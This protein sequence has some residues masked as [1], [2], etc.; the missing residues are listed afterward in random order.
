M[1]KLKLVIL[2][3]AV[4]VAA[5]ANDD[6]VV[7]QKTG[8]AFFCSRAGG[9]LGYGIAVAITEGGLSGFEV[10]L[11]SGTLALTPDQKSIGA[12]QPD[13]SLLTIGTIRSLE[14]SGNC[15]IFWMDLAPN[16]KVFSR[17]AMKFTGI[18]KGS[19]TV[20]PVI[21][22]CYDETISAVIKSEDG[23]TV[24]AT[25]SCL[26]KLAPKGQGSFEIQDSNCLVPR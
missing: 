4:S 25:G 21:G 7:Q 6:V 13:G 11:A 14:I 10:P 20:F 2:L 15:K 26:R 1:N 23:Q 8:G 16:S 19:G 17:D 3:M 24:L 5:R 18:C 22:K 12:I 9:T